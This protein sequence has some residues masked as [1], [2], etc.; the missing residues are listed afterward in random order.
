MVAWA[1]VRVG[2][3][4]QARVAGRKSAGWSRRTAHASRRSGWVP[5]TGPQRSVQTFLVPARPCGQ[6]VTFSVARGV[7]AWAAVARAAV[8]ITSAGNVLRAV[9]RTGRRRRGDDEIGR[10]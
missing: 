4:V 8:R 7:A 2:I 10:V 6:Y 3:S 1:E 9:V 5:P